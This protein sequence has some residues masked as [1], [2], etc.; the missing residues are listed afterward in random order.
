[1]KRRFFSAA[2][3]ASLI[4]SVSLTGCSKKYDSPEAVFEAAKAAAEKED[5]EAF[6]KCMT[7]GTQ[8]MF[9][10]T[11]AMSAITMKQAGGLL[12]AVG[13][14]EDKEA[15]ENMSAVLDKHGLTDEYIKG[16]GGVR[17]VSKPQGV[18]TELLKPVKDKPAF[19]AD[20]MKALEPIQKDTGIPKDVFAGELSNVKINGDS[21]TAVVKDSFPRPL[22]FK[23]VDGSWLIDMGAISFK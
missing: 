8:E 22:A 10:G 20:I 15:F 1:M 9:A 7:E 2:L 17:K 14:K 3:I 23:K 6:L 12:K 11:M 13:G 5:V 4:C 18:L 19:V 21:A 16:L